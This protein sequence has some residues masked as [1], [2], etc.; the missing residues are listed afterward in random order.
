MKS[1]RVGQKNHGDVDADLE[2]GGEVIE[3][4]LVTAPSLDG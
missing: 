2:E 1:A 4:S 3:H